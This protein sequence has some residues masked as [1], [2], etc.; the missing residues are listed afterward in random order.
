MVGKHI[1]VQGKV[2]GV[3]YRYFAKVQ[4]DMLGLRGWVRNL[5]SGEVEANVYGAER[6]VATFLSKLERG[7]AHAKVDNLDVTDIEI[8]ELKE[9]NNLE[10]VEFQ[11]LPD[12][13]G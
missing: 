12:G 1:L 4:A 6:A 2:Q 10:P 8:S 9:H 7:P 3:G 13:K 11:I 5:V